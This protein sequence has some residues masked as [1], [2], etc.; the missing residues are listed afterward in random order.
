MRVLGT[1]PLAV[2]LMLAAAGNGIAQQVP[3]GPNVKSLQHMESGRPELGRIQSEVRALPLPADLRERVLAMD[4]E[5]VLRRVLKDYSAR[6]HDDFEKSVHAR[7]RLL[8]LAEYAGKPEVANALKA[9]NVDSDNLRT[10]AIS[11]SKPE[12]NEAHL[13]SRLGVTKTG[14]ILLRSAEILITKP[15]PI[16]DDRLAPG[17]STPWG[18]PPDPVWRSGLTFAALVARI[19]TTPAVGHCSGTL[20]GAQEVLTAA[21]CLPTGSTSPARLAVFLPFQDGTETVLTPD[22]R[23]NSGLRRIDVVSVSWIGDDTND[24][25]PDTLTDFTSI[26]HDGKD[27]AILKLNPSQMRALPNAPVTARLHSGPMPVPPTTSAVGYG[28]SDRTQEGKLTLMV[29]VRDRLPNGVLDG[30]DRLRYADNQVSNLGGICGG[31]SGG[32]LFAGRIDGTSQ[33]PALIAV[34]SG[35]TS[36]LPASNHQVCLS[37]EQSHSS[38]LSTRNR[39]FVCSRVPSSCT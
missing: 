1:V 36:D 13:T 30:D 26:I 20:I 2:T 23:R 27:L 33:S 16:A 39:R 7:L 15:E 19:E 4:D 11:S 32:G 28:I 14:G 34:I 17:K 21:H 35:L 3:S 12:L 10:L 8:D 24:R 9:L 38:V 6:S 18:T 5:K 22:G 29:G 31:D 25:L 37:S